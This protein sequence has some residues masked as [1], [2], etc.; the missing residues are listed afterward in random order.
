MCKKTGRIIICATCGREKY[1]SGCYFK[2]KN[3]PKYCSI[4]CGKRGRIPWNKNKKGLQVAWNKGKKNPKILGNEYRKGL[5]PWNKGLKTGLI[6]KSAFKE[7]LIPWNKNKTNVYSREQ[8]R[9]M[10]R[11]QKKRFS[12][13]EARETI[14]QR[15]KECWQNAEFREKVLRAQCQQP[16]QLEMLFDEIT[17]NIVRY[18]GDRSWWRLLPNGRYKNPDFKITGQNKVIEIFGGKDYFHTEEEAKELLSLYEQVGL[19][20]LIFWEEEIL[21]HPDRILEKTISFL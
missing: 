3:P 4:S 18:V 15:M 2:R 19:K 6:P 12:I 14:S 20:C 17:P 7:G 10:G 8:L 21:K 9:K 16:N 1:Y 11:S 5:A 13:P